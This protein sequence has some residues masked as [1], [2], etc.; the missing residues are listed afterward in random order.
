[1]VSG[2][3]AAGHAIIRLLHAQGAGDIIG[4]DR[5]GAVHAGQ[6]ELRRVPRAGSPTHTNPRG[7]HG[8]AHGGAGRRRRVHRRLR[9]R[10]C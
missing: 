2:V 4:C 5:H 6:P 1:M 8:H 7:A 9:A 3:G 10:T